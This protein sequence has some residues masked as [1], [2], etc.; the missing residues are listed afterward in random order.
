MKKRFIKTIILSFVF[1]IISAAVC[2]TA[3]EITQ[4]S[5]LINNGLTMTFNGAPFMPLENDGSELRPITYRDRT[6]LPVRFVAEKAGVYVTYDGTEIILKSEN[7]LQNRA[8]LVLHC[9]KY[10]DFEQLASLVHATKGVI[11]SPYAYVTGSEVKFTPD[12]IKSIKTT[13]K[14]IWG[15]YDGSGF[16]MELNVGDYFDRFVWDH[17]FIQASRVGRNAVIQTGNTLNNIKEAFPGASFIEYNFP[18]F[19]PRFGGIDWASLR[20]VFEKSGGQWMLIAV[21]HDAWTI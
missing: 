9:L 19:D 8:D 5:A 4:I 2:F 14:Y 10:R 11:F 15:E 7:E 16:V 12:Q 18:G 17:D 21:I 3:P 1:S 13:D 20:L 6:Y